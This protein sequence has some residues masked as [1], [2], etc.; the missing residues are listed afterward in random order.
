[1]ICIHSRMPFERRKMKRSVSFR[2]TPENESGF[3]LVELLV[4]ILVIGILAAIAVPVFLNQRQKSSE[5]SLKSDLKNLGVA[6]ETELVNNKGKYTLPGLPADFKASRGNTFQVT[7]ETGNTNVAAGSSA[8][9]TSV[10]SGRA[11]SYSNGAYPVGSTVEDFTRY[12]YSSTMANTYGGPYWDY[13]PQGVSEI[14]AG[15]PFTGSLMVRSSVDVCFF[16]QFEQHKTTPGWSTI[17]GPNTCLVAGE[18]KEMTVSGTTEYVTTDITLT[19]YAGHISSSTFDFKEPVI[20]IGPSINKT[21]LAISPDQRYCVQGFNDN[22]KNNIWRYST[23]SG[24]VEKGT[25]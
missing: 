9:G 19:A 18:W 8:G 6:M 10:Y 1:M 21:N 20:V 15:S 25:C 17:K 12:T 5:A 13:V 11:A 7:P 24:G 16:L 14:P 2:R 22:D 3:T 4:V 23:L